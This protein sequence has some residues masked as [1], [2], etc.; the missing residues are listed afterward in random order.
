LQTGSCHIRSDMDI[1][2]IEAQ[3]IIVRE[4]KTALLRCP[5][6]LESK[7]ISVAG[8]VRHS[9]KVRCNCKHVFSIQ[10]DFRK[11]YRKKTDLKGHYKWK[12]TLAEM[13]WE[14]EI[15][16]KSKVNCHVVNLSSDGIGFLPVDSYD[17]KIGDSFTITFFLDDSAHTVIRKRATARVVS[18]NYV[19]CEFIEED[20]NDPKIGFYLL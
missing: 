15:F 11:K 14:I 7:T 16:D 19:G 1:N 20:K 4:G 5:N 8:M 13:H 6:C 9:F 12:S 18:K 10:L 3:K 17:F 2:T